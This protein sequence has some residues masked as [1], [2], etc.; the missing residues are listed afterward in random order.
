MI[1]ILK[2]FRFVPFI[3][4]LLK[5]KYYATGVGTYLV[6]SFFKRILGIN[7]GPFLLHFTSRLIDANNVKLVGDNL[8]SVYL[9]FATSGGC[10]YQCLNGIEIGEGTIWSYNCAFVSANHDLNDLTRHSQEPPIVIGRNV[11]L[12]ANCVVLPGVQIGDN[13]IIGAG[14]IV[15][16]SIPAFSIAV[17]NPARVIA[18]RCPKCRQ[19]LAKD[20]L[21]PNC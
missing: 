11:W 5:R 18:S 7:K 8:E 13:S 20:G 15:T 17:G 2:I 9:S 12:G 3:D 1:K 14:S 4:R 10:Y 19:K 16:Q 21:C 6:N